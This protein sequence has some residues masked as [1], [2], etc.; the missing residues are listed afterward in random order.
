VSTL[1]RILA[2]VCCILAACGLPTLGTIS[3][4]PLGVGLWIIATLVG[5]VVT[6]RGN[7]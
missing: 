2:A 4:F 7:P 1:F 3:L 6:V 5:D